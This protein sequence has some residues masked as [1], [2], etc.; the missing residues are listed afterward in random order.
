MPQRASSANTEGAPKAVAKS[1]E[2]S[3]LMRTDD[4]QSS[5]DVS[6]ELLE[7][8]PTDEGSPRNTI[9]AV[10]KGQN[11]QEVS[12][13]VVP[14]RGVESEPAER[15]PPQRETAIVS[16]GATK[17]VRG[18]RPAPSDALASIA[19]K[20]RASRRTAPALPPLE[21]KKTSVVPLL[22]APDN[23]ILNAEDITHQ[24]PATVVAEIIGERMFGGVTQALDPRLLALSGHLASSTQEQV[25]FRAQSREQLGNI[26]R[27][28][29]LMVTGL[30]ME[31]DAR[32][33]TLRDSVNRRVEEARLEENLSATSDARGNLAAVKEDYRS[34]QFDLR[35]TLEARKQAE[36][37]AGK[38][39]KHAQSL[40]AELSY[41]Q[42]VLKESDERAA[43]AEVRCEEVLK[44][45]SS[46]AEAFRERDEAV[47]QRE[48]VQHQNEQL[49]ADFDA[50]LTQRNEALARVVVLE[51][52]LSKQ[53][54]N[55]KDLTLAAEKSHL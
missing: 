21:K 11:A 37:E 45:L 4:L 15:A 25:A 44:Q 20:S 2:D 50:M 14:T 55:V 43:A 33:H 7:I 47:S 29:L 34:L 19:K 40:E 35:A 53:V 51:Q 1:T 9:E 23:D 22:S 6:M 32:D 38:V 52:E 28:M 49:K 30:F 39:Q 27:E 13:G 41:G 42:K 12:P 48:E 54:N 5:T 26:A 31:I 17:E 46:M 36:E 16:R 10:P 8:A 3:E 24:S 18:K